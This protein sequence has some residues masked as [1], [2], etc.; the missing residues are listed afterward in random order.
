MFSYDVR[1]V[2][3]LRH[4]PSQYFYELFPNSASQLEQCT[5]ERLFDSETATGK[6]RKSTENEDV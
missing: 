1:F 4:P 2:L 6:V 5:F 3:I